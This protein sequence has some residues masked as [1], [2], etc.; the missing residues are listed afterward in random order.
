M[1]LNSD[2]QALGYSL[3]IQADNLKQHC[4]TNNIVEISKFSTENCP[5]WFD[6]SGK[7]EN[8]RK[9]R[10]NSVFSHTHTTFHTHTHTRLVETRG[11]EPL[12]S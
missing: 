8:F 1:R 5:D 3:S 7:T 12:T 2:E 4:Q 10:L 9:S 11:I 6:H